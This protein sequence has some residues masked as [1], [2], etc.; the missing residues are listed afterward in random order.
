MAKG[1]A[2]TD[3]DRLPW[4]ALVRKQ[5][6]IEAQKLLDMPN[7][8]ER[9]MYVVCGCSALKRGYRELLSQSSSETHVEHPLVHND[10]VF[11]YIDVSREELVRRLARRREHFFNPVLLDTQLA[12]LEVPDTIHEEAIVVDGCRPTEHVVEEAYEKIKSYVYKR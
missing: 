8:R 3:S 9:P 12:T 2:L 1:I 7:T 4:L 10:V 11:V 6:D 5:L